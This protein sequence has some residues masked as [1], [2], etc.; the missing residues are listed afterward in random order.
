MNEYHDGI[1]LYEIMTDK[2][3]NKAIQDTIG[4]K[5][6]FN[7]NTNDFSLKFLQEDKPLGTAS[8]L[9]LLKNKVTKS[10]FFIEL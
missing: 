1:I 6:Y 9:G 4:V 8:S 7:E 10:F 2:V 3:W 5:A